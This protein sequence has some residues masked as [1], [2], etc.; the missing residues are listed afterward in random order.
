M[1]LNYSRNNSISEFQ[2]RKQQ[3]DYCLLKKIKNSL[4]YVCSFVSYYKSMKSESLLYQ[5]CANFNEF[6][7]LQLE[8]LKMY[9]IFFSLAN[10]CDIVKK[11]IKYFLI[12]SVIKDHL[13]AR[14]YILNLFLF[15]CFCLMLF[16]KMV[17]TPKAKFTRKIL[18][19]GREKINWKNT[20]KERQFI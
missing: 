12:L 18:G 4:L 9:L 3:P 8:T 2:F 13:R 10:I 14:S 20:K 5:S 11:T 15:F 7:I 1:N 17:S 6:S 19:R 16:S